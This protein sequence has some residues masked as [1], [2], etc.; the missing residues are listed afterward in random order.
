MIPSESKTSEASLFAQKVR[1]AAQKAQSEGG[2]VLERSEP[3][4]KKEA[5]KPIKIEPIKH[6]IGRLL[7]LVR[8]GRWDQARAMMIAD[9]RLRDQL[10]GESFKEDIWA[11][12]GEPAVQLGAK[13]EGREAVVESLIEGLDTMASWGIFPRSGEDEPAARWR[14]DAI[15]W[16]KGGASKAKAMS[17]W[18]RLAWEQGWDAEPARIQALGRWLERHQEPGFEKEAPIRAGLDKLVKEVEKGEFNEWPAGALEWVD[19]AQKRWGLPVSA[20]QWEALSAMVIAQWWWFGKEEALQLQRIFD[21]QEGSWP[22]EQRIRAADTLTWLGL[23]VDD[24]MIMARGLALGAKRRAREC[25]GASAWKFQNEEDGER[26]QERMEK[27]GI[28]WIWMAALGCGRSQWE[29]KEDGSKIKRLD[30][31]TC[32]KA[33]LGIEEM[34]EDAQAMP[35]PDALAGWRT[36]DVIRLEIE[37]GAWVSA[38]SEKGSTVGLERARLLASM[39]MMDLLK[40]DLKAWARAGRFEQIAQADQSGQTALSVARAMPKAGGKSG[41]IEELE[42]KVAAKQAKELKEVSKEV[43][44]IQRGPKRK[45]VRRM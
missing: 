11:N 17:E 37:E 6:V 34:V 27:E 30:R 42:A 40:E 45:T 24:P 25:W 12:W 41:W 39:S 22:V 1:Q 15:A 16:K 20:C 21:A 14:D 2:L 7:E 8:F 44:A 43:K 35:M 33:M 29:K 9:E 3:A 5:A 26:I 10:E 28:P 31:S 4:A 19:L 13:E 23:S 32:L 18:M 38:S 36:T